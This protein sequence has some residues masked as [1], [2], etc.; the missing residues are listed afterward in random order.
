MA[1]CGLVPLPTGLN[2]FDP[3]TEIFTRYLSDQEDPTTLPDNTI[4]YLYR[5]H[6]GTLWVGTSA[7]LS[8]MDETTGSFQ[9]YSTKDGLPN[10]TI[11]SILEDE[12][13]RL[14]IPTNRG[15]SRFDPI[16]ETFKT[17]DVSDG[18]QDIEFNQSSVLLGPDGEMY[19]G[20]INGLNYFHPQ[21][22]R[23]NN[24]IP[25]VVITKILLFN[26]PIPIGEDS[27][28]TQAVP[29]T[30]EIVLSYQ[31]D[32]LAFEY[33]ALH[34]SSPE[35]NQYAYFME[36]YDRD[37][38]YVGNRRFA[39]YTGIPPGDYTFRVI[40][41]N[42]DG[43]WNEVGDS[44]RIVI[45]RPFWQTGWF[46]G[47]MV[48]LIAGSVVGAL[49]LRI[50]FIEGQRRE[51]ARQV[52]ERTLELRV[53]KEA[54]EASNRAKS[55]FLTNVSH[56]LRT[57]LNAII[58]FSQLMIRTARSDRGSNLTEEQRDNLRMIQNS[59]EHL[60]GLINEVLQLSKIEAGRATLQE[61]R[62]QPSSITDG[63]GANVPLTRRAKKSCSRF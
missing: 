57:P 2:H 49:T 45:P 15:L 36:G 38:N 39:S 22:I 18:L 58:G 24:Y 5:D 6:R 59:G 42:S 44:I 63:I 27:V 26:E 17:Y 1:V 23:D 43:V 52:D 55:V 20:G 48:M 28:L 29:E 41:A 46:I 53:A 61:E 25:P 21:D 32:F 13:G 51:L 62:V 34:F 14:W 37:W 31:D 3:E 16:E 35:E 50:R 11:Y 8:R 56:E 4:L 30:D 9:T 10:E 12:L 54:A 47:L 40:A 19:F 60:L 33:A 7:G